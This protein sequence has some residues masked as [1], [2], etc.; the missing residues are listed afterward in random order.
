MHMVFCS[1]QRRRGFSLIELL[2]VIGIIAILL[3]LLLT[4]LSSAR[5]QARAIKCQAALREVANAF[6]L[7]ANDHRGYYPVARWPVPSGND[8]T[9]VSI[10]YWNDFIGRYVSSARFNQSLLHNPDQFG[11]ARASIMWG[12]P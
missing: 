9:G 3:A 10:L 12:C 1:Q 8:G 7:Y 2:V 4:S 11:R 5:R 6:F